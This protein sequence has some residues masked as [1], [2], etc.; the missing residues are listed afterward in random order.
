M[1]EISEIL[2]K[3]NNIN[4]FGPVQ[5]LRSY[6]FFEDVLTKKVISIKYL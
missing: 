1:P 6:F 3:K 5:V 4:N 2:T